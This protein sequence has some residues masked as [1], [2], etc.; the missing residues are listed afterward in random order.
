MD[1]LFSFVIAKSKSSSPKP[2][3]TASTRPRTKKRSVP[4]W[5]YQQ[6]FQ[7]ADP[8]YTMG[9]EVLLQQNEMDSEETRSAGDILSQD[10]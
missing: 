1:M 5:L 6:F 2:P 10:P 8:K 7:P 9:Y 4:K 3:V